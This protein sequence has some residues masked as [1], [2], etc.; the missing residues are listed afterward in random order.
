VTQPDLNDLYLFAMVVQHGGYSAAERAIDIPKSRLSRR[1][2]QLEEDLGARLIHRSTSKFSVTEIGDKV[3]Q[4]AVKILAEAQAAREIVDQSSSSPRGVVKI[5]MPTA[6]AD[7]LFDVILPQFL[8]ENPEVKVQAIVS[9]RRIDLIQEGVD[10]A[11]RVRHQISNEHDLVIKKFGNFDELLVASPEYLEKSGPLEHPRDLLQ[12][13]TLSM[14]D[15]ELRQ[16]WQ[17]HNQKNEVERVEIS[18]RLMVH[19]FHILRQVA[20]NHGGI[21]LV[22]HMFCA[23]HLKFGR[24]IEVLPGWRLPN[25]IC[26][27][28]YPEHRAAFPAVAKLIEYLCARLP[29]RI[30]ELNSRI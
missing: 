1:I 17:L 2:A 9:N 8:S 25:G 29:T 27:A 13:T 3:Y 6:L 14:S 20:L 26:H 28:V 18:P 11:L 5:S 22:P 7:G 24:L 15:D 16:V 4:H 23:Q 30:D 12:H 10:I 21:A 19:D